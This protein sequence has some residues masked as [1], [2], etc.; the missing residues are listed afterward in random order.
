MATDSHGMGIPLPAD[1]TKVHE[2]P[3]VARSGFEKVA[4][5]LAGGITPGIEDAVAAASGT[6]VAK[7]LKTAGIMRGH[8]SIPFA[9]D[10]TVW[11][12]VTEAGDYLPLGYTAAGRL[13]AFARKIWK[14]D[15][16]NITEISRHPTYARAIVTAENY[17]LA[18]LRWDGTIDLPGLNVPAPPPAPAPPAAPSADGRP[19]YADPLVWSMWGSSSAAGIAAE[20]SAAAAEHGA[21]FTDGGKGGEWSFQIAARLG[22]VP[23]RLSFPENTVP[24]SGTV[25]VAGGA[26]DVNGSSLKTFAG[27]VLTRSGATVAGTLGYS[28]GALR[29]TRT[30][31][32]TAEPIAPGTP[33]I[34]DLG[35]AARAGTVLLWMGKGNAG[36]VE[37]VIYETSA[38]YDYLAP[39]VKRCLVLGHFVNT[40]RT[41]GDTG[42]A[43]IQAINNAYSARYG[44]AYVDIS[45]YLTGSQVWADTGITPTADDLA[46]QKLGNKPPSLSSD[47]QHLNDAADRAVTNLII[48]R[49]QTLAWLPAAG[50]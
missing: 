22:S 48:R 46:E 40:G 15:V 12:Q 39:L 18:G 16:G 50:A 20:L 45:A 4:E 26:L 7:E 43:K 33:F 13:D 49:M 44:P 34:P 23:A 9:V 19:L 5:V 32:G 29:F 47:D 36:E 3:K 17:L 8:A 11:R 31:A 41:A 21:A 37:R 10:D 2:F 14:E 28:S 42:R 35:T 6:A 27:T 24:A 38:S 1:S 25:A 30:A